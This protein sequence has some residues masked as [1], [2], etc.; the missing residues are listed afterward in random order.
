MGELAT[1]REMNELLHE[2]IQ[3][4]NPSLEDV[5]EKIVYDSLVCLKFCTTETYKLDCAI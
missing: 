3:H 4:R 2:K 5:N 1:V